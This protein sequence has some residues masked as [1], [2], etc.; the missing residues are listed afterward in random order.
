MNKERNRGRKIWQAIERYWF[1]V[2]LFLYPLRHIH[3]GLD[4]W[5][6]GYNYSNFRYAGLDHMDPMWFFSTYL[7]NITGSL[8]NRLPFGDTLLGMNFYTGL[9]VGILAVTGY[10][11]CVKKVKMPA[12]PVFLGEVLA[13]SLCWCP[14]ALLY[15]YLTYLLFLAGFIFL[16]QGLKE[17]RNG[18][19]VL[20][21][22]CL[23]LNI[24]VRFPNIVQ[25]AM[26]LAVWA[27]GVVCR[28]KFSKVAA[29]TGW[30][31]LGYFGMVFAGFAFFA[32]KYGV[33][34]Y[35]GAIGRLFGMTE[36]ASDYTAMSMVMS[37]VN[38]YADMIYWI[39]RICVF[40]AAGVLIG[41]VIPKKYRGLRWSA[42][43]LCSAGAVIWLYLRQFCNFHFNEYNSMLRPG[44][45]FLML[46]VLMGVIVIIHPKMKAE[47]KLLSGMVILVIFLTPLGSNN[48]LYP[49]LNNLFVAGPYVFWMIQRFV[50]TGE[51]LSGKAG[52][53]STEPV[54][55][56]FLLFAAMML[57]QGIGFG[58]TFVFVEAAGAVDTDTKVENNE[59][60]KGIYMNSERAEWM[61]RITE[62]VKEKGLAG[63]EVIL[64]GQ[65][66]ALSFYLDM[67]PAFNSWCDLRSYSFEAMKEDMNGLEADIEAGGKLPV[68]ILEQAYADTKEKAAENEKFSLIHSFMEKYQYRETFRN[69][70]FILFESTGEAE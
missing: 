68:V 42:G 50:K 67:P 58:S 64:Y 12:G 19:L 34:A 59:V 14:T 2:I 9:F 7:A 55:A 62:Y 29:R 1:P 51:V 39:V 49:S 54:K 24:F 65:I 18:L 43:V 60:L 32:L 44:I 28:T 36:N 35:I 15:N 17:D 56:A 63:E 61:T 30:C 48:G 66:P 27:Y 40:V 25:A 11:F 41:S 16:Y 23:G 57:V 22:L 6:T 31:M 3:Q 26:I 47:D 13:V 53:L 37:M 38:S 69:D 21:G 4:L 33:S 10:L 70:K 46:A 45:L 20:A 52:R 8:L 5:D